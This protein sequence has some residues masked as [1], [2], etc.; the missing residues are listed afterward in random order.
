MRK[1]AINDVMSEFKARQN[2]MSSTEAKA[3]SRNNKPLAKSKTTK[4][5]RRTPVDHYALYQHKLE[6]GNLD[7]FNTQDIMYFFRDVANENG[8]RYIIS[9]IAKDKRQFKLLLERGISVEEVLVMIE[10]VFTS[11]QKYLDTETLH[12][13]IFLTNWCNTLLRDSKLWLDDK[14]DP[15]YKPSKKA[16]KKDLTKG[17]EWQG[18]KSE[19]DTTVGEWGF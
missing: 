15:D 7:K 9:N 12:P 19:S 5:V 11:G 4:G 17:R 16:P 3:S 1:V 2:L 8:N 6:S 13:G 14:F 18:S 10:F